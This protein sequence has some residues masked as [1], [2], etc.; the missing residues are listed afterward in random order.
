MESEYTGLSL[1]AK[2]AVWLRRLID[3]IGSAE[4]NCSEPV[5]I[6]A[7]NQ[8]SVIKLAE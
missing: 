3:G 6:L 4:I 1:A 5:P 8:G 2:E 7:D